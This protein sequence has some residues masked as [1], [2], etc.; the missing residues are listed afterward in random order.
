LRGQ[1]HATRNRARVAMLAR[2][3]GD[4]AVIDAVYYRDD[5]VRG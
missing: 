4:R 5:A 3:S 2:S 1:R